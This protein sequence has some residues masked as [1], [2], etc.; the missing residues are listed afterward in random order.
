MEALTR[1]GCLRLIGLATWP[2]IAATGVHAEADVPL[3]IK[4]YDP[5]AYFTISKATPGSSAFEYRW[6]GHLFRFARADHREMFKSEPARYA[7]QFENYCAMALAR[8]EFVEGNPENWMV[9]EGKLYIFAL[10]VGVERFR[11]ELA[12]NTERAGRNWQA[13]PSR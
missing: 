1:R 5:V 11:Q 12:G 2:G 8:G 9:S 10:P 3:A 4:G 13:A 7:P 6:D